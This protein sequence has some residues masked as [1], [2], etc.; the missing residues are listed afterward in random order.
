MKKFTGYMAGANL[1]HWI[2]QYEDK[3]KEHWDAYIQEP[4]FERMKSWGLDHVRLPVDY[5]LFESDDKP[6]VYDEERLGYIDRT[7]EWCKKYG[8]NLVLD[9]HH[10]PGFFFG[11]DGRN[12]LFTS[13]TSHDRYLAIWRMFSKRYQAEG[14]NLVFELLNE[15][16]WENSDPWNALWLETAKEI[17]AISPQRRVI[18]GSNNSA[19]IAALKDLSSVADDRIIFTFH[20]YEPCVFTH[21]LCGW[22]EGTEKQTEQ[23]PFPF[24]EADQASFYTGIGQKVPFE[25]YGIV[26]ETYLEDY[27]K[28]AADY[29]EQHNQMMYCGE[30]GVY[31]AAERQS[32]L[33]WLNA[34][35]N[36]MT[37]HGIGRAV[38]SYRG[39]SSITSPDN[40]TFD[41]D[42]VAAIARH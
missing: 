41:A 12:D 34:V 23:V 38:W 9:L 17:W 21:Q 6:C 2:S 37:R 13:V 31:C 18:I 40:K 16:K 14:D 26:D 5:M 24:A 27:V 15:L 3:G 4:D 32:T 11:N 33:N 7:L 30:Y 8:L 10:A 36:I 35:A 28:R 1:G 19:N 42:M 20:M 39:F 29:S 22:V 25:G